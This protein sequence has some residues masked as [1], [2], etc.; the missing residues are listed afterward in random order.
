MSA[1]G[2][3]NRKGQYG[4][5]KGKKDKKLPTSPPYTAYAFRLAENFFS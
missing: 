3:N 5:P 2:Y 4:T 1:N